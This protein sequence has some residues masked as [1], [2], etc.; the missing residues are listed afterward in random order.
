[1]LHWPACQI[2]TWLLMISHEP[3]TDG[4][5]FS[6]KG[7][8]Q[9]DDETQIC[10]WG[11]IV[12]FISPDISFKKQVRFRIRICLIQDG[13][14]ISYKL[15]NGVMGPPIKIKK[16]KNPWVCLFFFGHPIIQWSLFFSPTK[17]ICC[18]A[19]RPS[20]EWLERRGHYLPPLPHPSP[21]GSQKKDGDFFGNDET[22]T[23][24]DDSK[25]FFFFLCREFQ[26]N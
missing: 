22:T 24:R 8:F 12:F 18:V 15:V 11:R 3:G 4:H 26:P 20:M 1:M 14:P 17:I 6:L 23:I 16:P 21:G 9:L 25:P 13:P 19:P 7:W 5:P 2:V 10:T